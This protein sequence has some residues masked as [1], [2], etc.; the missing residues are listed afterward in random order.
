[1]KLNVSFALRH[2]FNHVTHHVIE[3]T[4]DKRYLCVK[5]CLQQHG[6]KWKVDGLARFEH[7]VEASGIWGKLF[8]IPAIDSSSV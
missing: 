6:I 3:M 2:E 8:Q 1:M 4:D 5:T 7:I